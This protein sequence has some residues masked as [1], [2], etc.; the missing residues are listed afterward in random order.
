[1]LKTKVLQ[2]VVVVV[3]KSVLSDEKTKACQKLETGDFQDFPYYI[4][5]MFP[6]SR[7]SLDVCQ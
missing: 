7:I 2:V 5:V 3:T 1:M 4:P 6:H